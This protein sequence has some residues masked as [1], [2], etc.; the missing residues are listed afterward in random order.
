MTVAIPPV[1]RAAAR[2]GPPSLSE[3]AVAAKVHGCCIVAGYRW[4]FRF[5]ESPRQ[6]RDFPAL[7]W[8]A[9]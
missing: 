9:A 4:R 1:R 5:T 2:T 6:L 8:L 3:I 7:P